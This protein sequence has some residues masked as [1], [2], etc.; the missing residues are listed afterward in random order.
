MAELEKL[1]KAR[2]YCQKLA[3]GIDPIS[4]NA[5]PSDCVL[6]QVQLARLF[7]Y[8]SNHLTDEINNDQV[9]SIKTKQKQK[10][11]FVITRSALEEVDLS[12]KP[13]PIS[14][15]S[16]RVDAKRELSSKAFSY[17]W[18]IAWLIKIELLKLSDVNEKKV[19]TESG[20][21]LGISQELRSIQGKEYWVTL[22][23]KVAQRFLID[24]MDAILAAQ[25]Y[26]ILP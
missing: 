8:L 12:D 1:I 10:Q 3:N 18:P 20:I 6:N 13:I 7:F 15:F 4:D 24:N 11:S 21:A 2:E 16:R 19:P 23:N 22:Y 26:T 14:E 17:K 5:M 25:G 9:P